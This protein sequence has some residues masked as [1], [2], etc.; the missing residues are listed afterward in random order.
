MIFENKSGF[1]NSTSI[2]MVIHCTVFQSTKDH[3][4]DGGPIGLYVPCSSHCG[5]MSCDPPSP[6]Q[7]QEHLMMHSS[8]LCHYNWCETVLQDLL[9]FRKRYPLP[10][11]PYTP[12]A[13]LHCFKFL[14]QAS[15]STSKHTPLCGQPCALWHKLW[16]YAPALWTAHETSHSQASGSRLSPSWPVHSQLSFLNRTTLPSAAPVPGGEKRLEK[17]QRPK[18]AKLT[19]RVQEHN[20]QLRKTLPPSPC[21]GTRHRLVKNTTLAFIASTRL[22]YDLSFIYNPHLD[23]F[24]SHYHS[25]IFFLPKLF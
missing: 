19:L 10:Q 13:R 3:I 1:Q 17:V 25:S 24:G 23:H 4:H 21:R 11:F 14:G 20:W 6:A 22:Y 18:Q 2:T 5:S 16:N 15:P 12:S 9:H 7:G 8:D